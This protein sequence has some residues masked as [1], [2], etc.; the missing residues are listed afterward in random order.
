LIV[1][2]GLT[3][4]ALADY[5]PVGSTNRL[6]ERLRTTI[7]G[8]RA[9]TPPPDS[10][11]S[12]EHTGGGVR[13]CGSEMIALAPRF[14]LVGQ[15][16]SPHP[17]FVWYMAQEAVNP[18]EFVLYQEHDDG[19]IEVIYSDVVTPQPAGYLA[20]SLPTTEPALTAGGTYL[21]E[22][23]AY[24]DAALQ[25]PGRWFS[26]EV[27]IVAPPEGLTVDDAQDQDAAT[28][29]AYAAQ[30][31]WYD[32]LAIVYD[33]ETPEEQ[34]LLQDLLLDLADLEEN[35]NDPLSVY[36]SHQLRTLSE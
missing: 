34:A 31:L 25:R 4:P 19:S 11:V 15:S 28:A 36:L 32:A 27:D 17:T 33:G 13:G 1:F 2:M 16:A 23:I 9:Y 14:S 29:R 7:G 12:G 26:A 10:R 35:P 22:V 30:G 8:T 24:C 6:N 5:V 21:W 20:Y 3:L 18:L